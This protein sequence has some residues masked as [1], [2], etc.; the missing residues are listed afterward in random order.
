MTDLEIQLSLSLIKA[1]LEKL[2]HEVWSSGTLR[3]LS[4]LGKLQR[5]QLSV[6]E[7]SA[8]L[9]DAEVPLWLEMKTDRGQRFDSHAQKACGGKV[10]NV[11]YRGTG[12]GPGIP[13][14][15]VPGF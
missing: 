3:R 13:K 11:N 12:N 15:W 6:I 10:K 5:A 1:E 7:A 8:R 2:S 9:N 14:S 4:L